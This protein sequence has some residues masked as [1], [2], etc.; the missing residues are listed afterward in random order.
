MRPQSH[1]ER[2]L[3]PGDYARVR[4]TASSRWAG[5][6]GLV[7]AGDERSVLLRFGPSRSYSFALLDLVRV[8][9]AVRA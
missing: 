6:T 4:S 1:P 7:V 2:P 8:L 9:D 3:R 5:R